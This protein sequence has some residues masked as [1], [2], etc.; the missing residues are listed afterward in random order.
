MG[1]AVDQP[2]IHPEQDTLGRLNA[3]KNFAQMVLALDSTQGVVVGVLG[4]WGFG[5]T[6]FL[7]L[8]RSQ[9]DGSKIHILE[10][11]PWMFSGADQLVERFFA[12]LSTQVKIYPGIAQIGGLLKDYGGALNGRVASSMKILGLIIERRK[13]ASGGAVGELRSK[14]RKALEKIDEPI[15]VILDDIDRLTTAE[16]KSVFKLVRLTANF[17]NIIYVM[18]F[19]REHVEKALDEQGLEGRSYLD[20]ILQVAIDLPAIPDQTLS[21][22]L[23]DALNDV[24]A[25]I[26]SPLHLGNEAWDD[27]FF[28]I[29]RPLI[30][31]LR[32]VRRYAATVHGALTALNGQ[33]AIADV[34]ALEAVRLFLPN[35]FAKLHG[36]VNSL[37][38]TDNDTNLG[39]GNS[40]QFKLQIDDLVK[41]D[42]SQYSSI[43][44]SMI[45]R[46][47]PAAQ[48]HIGERHYDSDWR[49]EWIRKRRVAHVDV[50]RCY[51]ERLMGDGLLAFTDA[52]IAFIHMKDT[53]EFEA[54]LRLLDKSHLK[55]VIESLMT[56]EDQF[57]PE[58][59]VPGIVRWSWFVGQSKGK[60][61]VYSDWFLALDERTLP[62]ARDDVK[63]IVG[64][65]VGA[66]VKC[67]SVMTGS[68]L[69]VMINHF[70]TAV[71][72]S[73]EGP[74][75]SGGAA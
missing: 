1:I 54:H 32:N 71:A 9:I 39:I 45:H 5:K 53:N 7:N 59:V 20:K 22:Q 69:P 46:L 43:I 3:A 48:R 44:K 75:R 17:P 18:A 70:A 10:F 21:G 63:G 33:V 31:N 12:E 72:V 73:P 8:A 6:S 74:E 15:I 23:L 41:T 36:A 47:F 25:D 56:L 50:L 34:L 27:I 42:E 68:T 58:H 37:T 55:D 30:L 11:N 64:S 60:L 24:I 4:P 61:K 28:E 19:D 38:N 67:R 40:G 14:I 2:I 66:L 29:I 57:N 49:K 26:E 51:L 35:V 13:R 16:I 52:E 65:S 62:M